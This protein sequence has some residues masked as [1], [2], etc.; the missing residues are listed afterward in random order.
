MLPRS[1]Y[2]AVAMVNSSVIPDQGQLHDEIDAH[3]LACWAE[4]WGKPCDEVPYESYGPNSISRYIVESPQEM[5]LLAAMLTSGLFGEADMQ[6]NQITITAYG[7]AYA[8]DNATGASLGGIYESAPLCTF[9]TT[10]VNHFVEAITSLMVPTPELEQNG[11]DGHEP[12]TGP[13]DRSPL[14]QIFHEQVSDHLASATTITSQL[15]V[16]K[17]TV[18][19]EN[20][21]DQMISLTLED[22]QEHEE[23]K[24]EHPRAHAKN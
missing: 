19:R 4:F 9:E 12:D 5:N 8:I 21:N 15:G 6:I 1:L 22:V 3:N 14:E 17:V 2:R 20:I 18:K 23:L 10:N 16:L 11:E 7:F 24:P 13:F